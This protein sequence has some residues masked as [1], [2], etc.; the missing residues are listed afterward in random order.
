[1]SLSA[2]HVLCGLEHLAVCCVEPFC[3]SVGCAR[4]SA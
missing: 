2:L 3:C 1:L 4:A